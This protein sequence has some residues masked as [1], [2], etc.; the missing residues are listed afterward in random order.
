MKRF[1]FIVVSVLILI[2]TL[3]S[4]NE[5]NEDAPLNTSESS[6]NI[7]TSPATNETP[8][9]ESEE[10]HSHTYGKWTVVNEPDCIKEGK[11][12]R[13]CAC[14]EKETETIPLTSHK[15]TNGAC[16]ICKAKDPNHFTPDYKIGEA[17]TVGNDFSNSSYAAQGD[18]LYFSQ[19]LTQISKVK[20]DGSSLTKV[21]KISSGRIQT[22]N[23]VGDWIYFY[24]EGDSEA[25]SYIA[26]VRTDGSN[27]E[28]IVT[29]VYVGNLLV[30]K[31]TVLFTR[32][33]YGSDDKSKNWFSL[34]SVSTNGGTAKQLHDG[35][36]QSIVSDSNYVYFIYENESNENFI[37]RIKPDGTKKSLLLS[38]IST[39]SELFKLTDFKNLT[40][41]NSKLFFTVY[42]KWDMVHFI[43]SI[44][45]NGGSYTTYDTCMLTPPNFLFVVGNKAYYNG[46]PSKWDPESDSFDERSGLVE[47]DMVNKRYKI[48]NENYDH[49]YFIVT[50]NL[51]IGEN[52]KNEVLTS[53]TVYNLKAGTTKEIKIK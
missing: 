21:Y 51:I 9:Q 38:K 19:S 49:D 4:C 7:T 17:N 35:V 47:Y 42:N 14:G 11:K 37:Y 22:I 28:K 44:S 2:F 34:Y 5:Q 27:F 10:N 1:I 53:I 20:K 24:C 41:K 46:S 16:S 50:G 48:I 3:S 13:L 32:H 8:S 26:K 43:A 30:V 39:D 6:N 40:V 12:E 31:D 25:K 45:V 18:W 23:V 33:S 36:V 52:Y 15:Y 29:S